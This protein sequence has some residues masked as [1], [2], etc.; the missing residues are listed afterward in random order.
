[1]T[2]DITLNSTPTTIQQGSTLRD[3]V[4]SHLGRELDEQGQAADGTKLGLAVAVNGA[5]VPRSAWAQRELAAGYT[6]ELVTAA[7]GG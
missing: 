2:I 7:Q 4:S 1:M 5:V 3:L 6:V